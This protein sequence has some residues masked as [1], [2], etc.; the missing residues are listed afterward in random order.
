MG[1]HKFLIFIFEIY[2]INIG[3]SILASEIIFFSIQPSCTN[4]VMII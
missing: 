1:R 4:G 2:L 3:I